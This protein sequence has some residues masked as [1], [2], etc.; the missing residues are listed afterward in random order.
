[1]S[2]F[3]HFTNTARRPVCQA[4]A[5]FRD[6]MG[7][8]VEHIGAALTELTFH[9]YFSLLEAGVAC[10]CFTDSIKD[11][12]FPSLVIESFSLI[13]NAACLHLSEWF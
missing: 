4:C 13:Q 7:N 6:V 2:P 9:S 8:R 5:G 12:Y 11:P 3:V 10:H 1:M